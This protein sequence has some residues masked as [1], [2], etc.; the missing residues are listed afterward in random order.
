MDFKYRESG[1]CHLRGNKK[2]PSDKEGTLVKFSDSLIALSS[3]R[4]SEVIHS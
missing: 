3:D 4:I 1:S 2:D